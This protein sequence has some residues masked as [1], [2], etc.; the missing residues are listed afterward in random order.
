MIDKGV[1]FE[2]VKIIEEYISNPTVVLTENQINLINLVNSEAK[3]DE[4]L[5]KLLEELRSSSDKNAIVEKYY[6][7]DEENKENEYE[8]IAQVFGIGINSI[9][10]KYLSN[11]KEIFCF[12][13]ENVGR[14]VILENNKNGV[15]LVEQLKE[16]QEL[17][18]KYQTLNDEKNAENIL[19]DKNLKENCELSLIPIEEVGGHLK[20]VQGL[21]IEDYYKLIFMIENSNSLGISYINIENSLGLDKNGKIY[22]VYKDN[23]YEYKIGEPKT[24][25]YNDEK[26]N[27]SDKVNNSYTNLKE[28]EVLRSDYEDNPN[29]AESFSEGNEM[30]FDELPDY[31]QEKVITFY[32]N[33]E[34]LKKIDEDSRQLWIKYVDSYKKKIWL[35]ER[36]NIRKQSEKKVL[37]RKKEENYGF[38]NLSSIISIIGIIVAIISIILVVSSV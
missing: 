24:L 20:Q 9:E 6:V 10:H 11:G 4:K 29:E 19:K 35:D 26:I 22:E 8:I 34:L 2:Y 12:Y 1:L 15:S 14:N 3:K 31:I 38:I 28:N 25:R 5:A 7:I 23:S 21:L 36:K 18:E 30:I 37:A 16:I 32:N 17:N 13:D 33:P 27:T